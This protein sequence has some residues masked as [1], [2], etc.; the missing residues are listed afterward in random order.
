MQRMSP[1][2]RYYASI[3]AIVVVAILSALAGSRIAQGFGLI[4]VLGLALYLTRINCPRC[5]RRLGRE[6][7]VGVGFGPGRHCPGCGWDLSKR[8]GPG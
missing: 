3:L 5:G 2:W 8:Q 6:P 1:L 4:V 7:R